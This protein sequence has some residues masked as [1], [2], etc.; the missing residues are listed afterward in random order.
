M[1]YAHLTA[2]LDALTGPEVRARLLD[3]KGAVAEVLVRPDLPDLQRERLAADYAV[4]TAELLDQAKR[5]L[6]ALSTILDAAE[7]PPEPPRVFE[8]PPG[9]TV[10]ETIAVLDKISAE[11]GPPPSPS[12]LRER[13]PVPP[14]R[15][16]PAPP[17]PVPEPVRD[18]RPVP[19]AYATGVPVDPTALRRWDERTTRSHSD[20]CRHED[21]HS[22]SEEGSHA[23]ESQPATG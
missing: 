7:E 19:V 1:S 3:A 18:S 8:V 14:L 23:P 5:H 4:L 11:T 21:A 2:D 13:R 10:E 15:R 17:P 6:L 9:T 16:V 12:P 22:E 20:A